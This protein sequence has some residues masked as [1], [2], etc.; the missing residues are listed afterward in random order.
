MIF[1]LSFTERADADLLKLEQDL[2]KKA[3]LKAVRRTL[4]LMEN[5]LRHPSLNTH[6]FSSLKG[7]KVKR[8][9]RLMLNKI[10]PVHI[11]YFGIMVHLKKN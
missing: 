5:N 1:E 2:S 7:P 4:A 9:L 11:V 8:S 3:I 6:E 10:L